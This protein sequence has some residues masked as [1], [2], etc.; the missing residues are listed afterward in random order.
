[1]KRLT[2]DERRHVIAM[3]NARD[4]DRWLHSYMAIAR[5]LGVSRPCISLV[6]K[7][8]GLPARVNAHSF[9]LPAQLIQMYDELSSKFGKS[10]AY[11]LV[12]AHARIRGI[13]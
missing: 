3:A 8:A 12:R 13:T 2:Q 11:K 10:A 4:G 1:M 9:S 6:A 7:G 5:R